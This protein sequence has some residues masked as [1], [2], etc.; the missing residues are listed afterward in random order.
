[1]RH[2]TGINRIN[3]VC[4]LQLS[5]LLSNSD[6][7]DNTALLSLPQTPVSRTER[8]ATT[9][10]DDTAFVPDL[11]M[12]LGLDDYSDPLQYTILCEMP[13]EKVEVLGDDDL[14]KMKEK[15]VDEVGSLAM[16]QAIKDIDVAC[17]ILG[18]SSGT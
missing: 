9:P 2:S 11:D 6:Y 3:C 5:Q 7:F 17:D 1:M 18:I 14:L 15:L 13:T 4:L 16:T 12:M 8:T 10:V